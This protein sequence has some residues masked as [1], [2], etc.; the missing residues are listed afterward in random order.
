VVVA[1]QIKTEAEATQKAT[2]L[3]PTLT[4]PDSTL[5]EAL[6]AWRTRQAKSQGMPPYI[7]FSNKV[8]EAIAEQRPLTTAQLGKI[9]GVGPAKLEQY[10][11]AVIAL[12]RN[13][14]G[15]E[16]TQRISQADTAVFQP[17]TEDSSTPTI[18]TE[19]IQNRTLQ[20]KNP[21]EAILAVVADLE[22]LLTSTGL[23]H[24]LTAAPGEIVSFS[25]HE[26]CG[27]FHRILTAEAVEAQI[28][29]AIQAN[30]LILTP[31]QHLILGKKPDSRP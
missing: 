2:V 9:S 13:A 21:L 8:L 4:E 29:A 7:I 15:D 23:V 31:Q 28:Q 6:R 26:L 12:V 10:G 3:P 30:Y 18:A 1:G 14:L 22:G 24:L 20:I 19:T 25:D 5:L 17:S 16:T 11:E 27:A